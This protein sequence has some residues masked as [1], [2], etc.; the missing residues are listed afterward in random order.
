MAAGRA[1]V[2]GGGGPVGIAWEIGLAAGLA[3]NGIEIARA[4]RIIGTSAGSF[5]GASLASGRAPQSLLKAQIEQGDRD[6]AAQ[7]SLPAERG[8]L[9]RSLNHWLQHV[10]PG[11]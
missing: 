7:Q 3:E 4:D 2:L 9:L 11:L 1:F 8:A 6:S 5:A 10:T